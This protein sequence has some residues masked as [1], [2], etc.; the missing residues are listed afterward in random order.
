M[1]IDIRWLRF[2]LTH[3]RQPT[4][5]DHDVQVTPAAASSHTVPHA[6]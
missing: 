2:L 4:R 1:L 3:W 6:A 5:S